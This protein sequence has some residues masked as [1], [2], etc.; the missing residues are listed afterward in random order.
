M[1]RVGR[2]KE[3]RAGG[4]GGGLDG[5]GIQFI[6]ESLHGLPVLTTLLNGGKVIGYEIFHGLFVDGREGRTTTRAK[7]SLFWVYPKIGYGLGC[8]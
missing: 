8:L 4:K 6:K 3:E 5:G 2:G 7:E 1:S